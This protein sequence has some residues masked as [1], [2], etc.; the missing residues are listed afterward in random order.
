MVEEST[1]LVVSEQQHGLIPL[2]TD[3][4]GI[5]DLL[6]EHLAKGDVARRVHGV[7]VETAAGRV[8]VRELR[9]QAQ[10]GVL[11]EVLQR[12]HVRLGILGSPVEEQGVG[13]EG[14]IRTI[15]IVPADVVLAGDLENAGNVDARDIEAL[16]ILPMSVCSSSNCT[17]AIR[18]RWL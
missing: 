14:T 1:R 15:I 11:E 2:R 16:V 3:A 17:Q 6:D 13:I 8:D 9:Q 7:S 10:I 5:V 18:V 4:E 12:H